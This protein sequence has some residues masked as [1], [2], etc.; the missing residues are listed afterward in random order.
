MSKTITY[1][2]SAE[3][4]VAPAARRRLVPTAAR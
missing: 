4:V 2:A 3:F 1:R